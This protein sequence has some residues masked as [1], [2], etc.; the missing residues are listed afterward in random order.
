MAVSPIPV[1]QP[2]LRHAQPRDVPE[3]FRLINHWADQKQMLPK[4]LHHLFKAVR[5]FWVVE[6]ADQ[7]LGCGSLRIYNGELAEIA[8]L[9]I[10]PTAQGRGFGRML[11]DQCIEEARTLGL[12]RV[13]GL[14]Y[15]VDFFVKLGFRVIPMDD[16]PEK[17]WR[18]CVDC[19]FLDA[20]NE[21][22]V[23]INV[24]DAAP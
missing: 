7:V 23:L 17:V 21:T 16:L 8:S 2:T 15:Q 10:D 5:D 14:T 19:P 1:S 24:P 20:C 3:L 18:D 9:A 22:A 11:V 13:F 12:K 4:S 6:E